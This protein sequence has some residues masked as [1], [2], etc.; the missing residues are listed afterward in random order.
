MGI[1]FHFIVLL[2]AFS[3][4]EEKPSPQ[5]EGTKLD[6]IMQEIVWCGPRKETILIRTESN[7]VYR[8]DNKWTTFKKITKHMKKAADEVVE[9]S[10]EIGDVTNIIKSDANESTVVFV[11]N[12]GVIWVSTD[13]G[14]SM[15]AVNKDFKIH[16]IKLH[17]SELTWM[18]AIADQECKDPKDKNC[19]EGFH[20]LYLTQDM[21]QN[22]RQISKNVV[23]CE[24]P[25]DAEQINNGIPS[26]RIFATLASKTILPQLV[27]TDDFFR[28]KTLLVE[29]CAQFKLRSFYLFAIQ[30]N[31]ELGA[32]ML[33]ANVQEKFSSFYQTMFPFEKFKPKE[34]HILDTSENAVFVFVKQSLGDA[35]GD[36][37]M[38]DSTGIRYSLSLKH[39]LA[40]VSIGADFMKVNGIE[41]IY[42]ANALDDKTVKQIINQKEQEENDEEEWEDEESG[43]SGTRKKMKKNIVNDNIHT[44]ITFNKGGSWRY[45][46][47]PKVDSK[48]KV[49]NCGG[50]EECSLQLHLRKLTTVPMLSHKNAHGI[51]LALG[52]TGQSL[53]IEARSN[54]FLSR[55]GGVTWE[56]IAKGPHV[57][58]IAD[59]GGLLV[60]TRLY[61][62]KE[63]I[64][65]VFYSWN[66]GLT[67]ETLRISN[68]N[69]TIQDIFTE[70]DS[71]TQSFLI[72][73]DSYETRED[74]EEGNKF[75]TIFVLNFEKTHERICG[76]IHSPGTVGSD[77]E[78]WSPYDGRHGQPCLM[79][80]R[81]SYT[82]RKR[83]SE[84]FNGVLFER[85]IS[86]E[87]CK[88]TEEDYECDF[89]FTRKDSLSNSPCIPHINIS[90]APPANCTPGSIYTVTMGYRKVA[91]DTC[92]GGISHDPIVIPCSGSWFAGTKLI[93][94]LIGIIVALLLALIY[95]CKHFAEIKEKLRFKK[96]IA[97][98]G[99][100]F[101]EVKYSRIEAKNEDGDDEL[102][103][104]ATAKPV[105]PE[106]QGLTKKDY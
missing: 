22:W 2:F 13:C 33:V 26:T 63:N 19:M 83:D 35:Y 46:T 105:E 58:D 61:K 32:N 70:P 11:G 37:F 12:K 6:G 54:V 81:I 71:S 106:S 16:M 79:G 75:T 24:W 72:R 103:I 100:E 91:G 62:L 31:F 52:N 41:G 98:K 56:E 69:I 80:R 55:D 90:Y 8:S 94:L 9:N 78:I 65:D 17:P 42:I 64:A 96:G 59:H 43:K 76:G 101:K 84:C 38:S 27:S 47:A 104:Q 29:N 20:A 88:C 14:A 73:A 66:E 1:H 50:N 53:D 36:L 82:R 67:W 93:I 85:P 3:L 89:G 77:Y 57:Y 86:V 28:N 48:K 30:S 21:G 4:C 10:E 5:I 45:I 60:Q 25:F 87:T 95:L 49:I 23:H 74:E 68:M 97:K 51:I 39:C 44:Y 15:T 18:L 92:Q 99:T 40:H 102:I 7:A 34:F